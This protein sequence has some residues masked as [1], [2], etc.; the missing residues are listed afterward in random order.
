VEFADGRIE[1]RIVLPGRG[2]EERDGFGEVHRLAA[3]D[4]VEGVVEERRVGAGTSERRRQPG[5][6]L[7]RAQASLHPRDIAVD[8][9]DLAVVAEEPERLG[10]LPARLGVRR[11]A[12]VEDR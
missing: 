6:G 10:P 5:L 1:P 12:L 9:V 4:E 2:D 7:V 3:H 11:E 8:R